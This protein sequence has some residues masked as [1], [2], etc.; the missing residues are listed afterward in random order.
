MREWVVF[1]KSCNLIGFEDGQYSPV[2]PAHS[3][4][5]PNC[6]VFSRLVHP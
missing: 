6:C 3:G 2:R 5:Y 1:Y 4:R